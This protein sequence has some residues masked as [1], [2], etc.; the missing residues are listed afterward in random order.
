V[1]RL[2]VSA[3][4][5]IGNLGVEG[6]LLVRGAFQRVVISR[7]Q[8]T[9]DVHFDRIESVVRREGLEAVQRQLA[10][11]HRYLP[12]VSSISLEGV[13]GLLESQRILE[14]LAVNSLRESIAHEL[15]GLGVCDLDHAWVRRQYA[16]QRRPPGH[17]P[18]HW[19]QDGG[20]RFD[21]LAHETKPYPAGA[22]LNMVTCWI[23]LTACGRSAPGLELITQRQAGLLAPAELTDPQILGRFAVDDFCRPVMEP[24]DALLFR[25]DI[26]HRTHVVPDM[27]DDRTSIELRFFPAGEIPDRL[28]ADRFI[29]L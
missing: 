11:G 14:Y 2:A 10:P 18:H 9:A 1:H 20:L 25:G 24:G 6:S 17:V 26:L 22:L 5:T 8:E 28:Q 23:P 3:T 4:N 19:H 16:I 15:G 21:F 12:Q 7:W 27:S 13:Y 29:D